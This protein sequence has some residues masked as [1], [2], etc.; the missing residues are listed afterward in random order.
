MAKPKPPDPSSSR[1]MPPAGLGEYDG[2]AVIRIAPAPGLRDWAIKTFIEE[3]GRLFNEEHRHLLWARFECLWAVDSFNRQGRRVLGLCE[4]V[5]FR[6]SGWPRWRQE[7]QLEEWF[8]AG[9]IPD[10][11][12]T[13]DASYCREAGEAE[14]CA[15][16]EHELYHIGHKQDEF[17]AP[18]FTQD[19]M[20][21]LY[22]RGHDVEEFVGVVR[23]YGV[24]DP[25]GALAQ[26]VK[27]AGSTPEVSRLQMS[28]ACGT[29]LLRA[30]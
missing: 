8:G 30:A 9:N 1:P 20:P 19:G 22:I 5:S 18:A 27:A 6:V 11:L 12:I 4:E 16:V 21:K 2:K 24:G 7:Q 3:D 14:F 29:C 25:D 26:L 17:G 13:L 28:Q 10:Y 15:L 23:R